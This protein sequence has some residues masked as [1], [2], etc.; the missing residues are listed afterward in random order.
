MPPETGRLQEFVAALLVQEGA[1]VAAL[2]PD[3]LE[4]LAPPAVQHLLDVPEL[5][6]LGF[7][8]TLPANARRVGLEQDWLERFGRLLGERGRCTRLVLH[9]EVR[10]PSDPERA[11][12]HELV[13]DNATF[14]LLGITPAWTRYL[15]FSF[16]FAALSEEKREGLLSLGVNLATGALPDAVLAQIAP[17]LDGENS[18]PAPPDEELP[19]LWEPERVRALIEDALP[20]RL[21]ASLAP[22]VKALLRR[23]GR[24]QDRLHAY[25]DEL[26]QDAM[27]R[28]SGISEG[29]P[30]RPREE[31]RIAAIKR[32][33]QAKIDDLSRQY[34]M[35]VSVEWVQTLDLAMPVQRFEIQLRRRKGERVIHLDWNPL[36]R[37][38][39]APACEYGRSSERPRL[40]CD[41]A[42]HLV[43]PAGL[44]CCAGCSKPFCRACHR[45]ACPK[46]GHPVRRFVLISGSL[47]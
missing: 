26:H 30:A 46:C 9:P 43:T 27:R 22:F 3:G 12:G 19:A 7:G 44:A 13:L 21:Q 2:E 36:A 38:L 35:R 23:L 5:C 20:S 29:D 32:E 28:L 14:R 47:Q 24:D 18:Q 10:A 31:L 42:M 33:Y 39:E 1:L 16:R 11:L 25:H 8:A 41:Q 17:W 37:R 15:V 6:G 45:E 34:A 4:V 40:L